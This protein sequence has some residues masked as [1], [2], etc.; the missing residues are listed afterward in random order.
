M[1]IRLL[2]G[3]EVTKQVWPLHKETTKRHMSIQRSI[4]LL[5][6]TSDEHAALLLTWFCESENHNCGSC[7]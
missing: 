4:I 5:D 7:S 1:S 6:I 2:W 3:R